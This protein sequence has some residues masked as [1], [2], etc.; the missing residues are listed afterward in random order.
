MMKK[1][2]LLF[3]IVLHSFALIACSSNDSNIH[4]DTA[5]AEGTHST[6]IGNAVK[7]PIEGAEIK[8]YYF[9][10]DG[11]ETEITADNAPVL[12]NT[13]GGFEFHVDAQSLVNIQAPLVLRSTGGTMGRR[14]APKLGSIISEMT[15][16]KTG[17][18]IM[19]RHLSTASSVAAQLLSDR[20]LTAKSPPSAADADDCIS[21][22]EGALEVD[23]NQDPVDAAQGV[24]MVNNSVD[25]NLDLI[26][27]PDNGPAVE[28]YI[29]YLAK[30]LNS[31][32]GALDGEMED[33]D[34]PNQDKPAG[35]DGL[36]DGH[37]VNIC[38][39]GPSQFHHLMAKVDKTSIVSDGIDTATILITLKDGWGRSVDNDQGVKLIIKNAL[40]ESEEHTF[41]E[42]ADGTAQLQINATV[43]GQMEIQV[44]H[45]LANG[46]IIS[47]EL[48]VEVVDSQN[49]TA[50]VAD[51][52]SDQNVSTGS[53][54]TLDGNQSSDPNNDPLT[55]A[56][57]LTSTPAGSSATLS[58]STVFN[59]TFTAD[60]DGE[61][62]AELVVNDGT[63]DS[64]PASVTITAATVDDNSAPTAHAGQ[65]QN[66]K[67]GS[68]VTLD[69]S[70]S[71]DAD[72]DPLTYQW[73]L[74]STPEGSS[75]SLSD[76]SGSNPSFT[77]DLDGEYVATLVVSDGIEES[78][79][80]NV[81]ITASSTNS[82]PTA[83]AGPDQNVTLG[84][85]VTLDGSGSSDA[86]ND[87][88]TYTWTMRSKPTGS[89]ASLSNPE[90]E[91][92]SFTA[93][94]EGTYEIEL[95]VHD[96]TAAGTPATVTITASAANSAP[97]ADAGRD[98][99]VATNE[100]VGIDGTGS[101]DADN[102]PLTYA[103]TIVS[104]PSGS[105]VELPFNANTEM[106]FITPDMPGDYVIQLVVN[107][108]TVDSAADTVTI[109]ATGTSPDGAALFLNNCSGQYCHG[110]DG[111]DGRENIKGESAARIENIL[112]PSHKGVTIN[113][114]GNSEGANAI[115]DFLN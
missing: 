47:C 34:H 37:L 51:A 4:D 91:D 62:V 105:T 106:V 113:E 54:V 84:S 71:Q 22:V 13:T 94:L 76:A 89:S 88:I 25:Q 8:L 70:G 99:N 12:T 68:Q 74:T 61:Y 1:Y 80:V 56:W 90:Q 9:T 31:S 104:K 30:N 93:D 36:G 85:E 29:D 66:V 43:A 42:F 98:Q 63:S 57:T 33:P 87:P 75:A 72:N 102:D 96:G 78:A 52:G 108:G 39:G 18:H 101:S 48:L 55:Y 95:V 40:G 32:S 64:L 26:N 92:P 6:I 81:T 11:T 69:G 49:N 19:T 44:I 53:V 112:T 3:T 10:A 86:D 5:P 20:A 58:D 45:T 38:P 59:P 109:T 41:T 21:K 27:T 100:Q 24:A 23:L 115:A 15:D 111:S 107:D 16:L 46:N 28:E 110:N 17:G 82:A 114:I 14:P 65:N 77:A 79:P 67:T 7:G 60:V 73:E 103:W 50:P 83:D 35:F 2:V 97:I